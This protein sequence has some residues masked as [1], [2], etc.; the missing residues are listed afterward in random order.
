MMLSP[1]EASQATRLDAKVQHVYTDEEIA[2]A[3]IHALD[4]EDAV[5]RGRISVRVHDGWVTLEGIVDRYYQKLAA[6]DAVLDLACDPGIEDHIIV[7]ERT[8]EP[9]GS[10]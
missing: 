3:A 7:V 4:S 2:R 1:Q 6:E 8:D 5:P 9:I 10:D